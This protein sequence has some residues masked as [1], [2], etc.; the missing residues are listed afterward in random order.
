MKYVIIENNMYNTYFQNI[1]YYLK[2]FRK[3]KNV[4]LVPYNFIAPFSPLF[5]AENTCC[6]VLFN[7]FKYKLDEIRKYRERLI[8]TRYVQF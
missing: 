6:L 7:I 5:Y 4:Y 8:Y 2:T 1:N 3:M